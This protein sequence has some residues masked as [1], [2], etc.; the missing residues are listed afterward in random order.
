MSIAKAIFSRKKSR[1][2]VLS[3][4]VYRVYSFT[5][6]SAELIR[7]LERAG[8]MLRGV[9][10]SHHVY[11]HP[12]RPGHLSV[13]HPRKDLGIGLARKLLKQAGLD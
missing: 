3:C 13:P 10:G 4:C 6:N 2:D 5:M 8:W 12:A 7:R 11:A 1:R 9:K